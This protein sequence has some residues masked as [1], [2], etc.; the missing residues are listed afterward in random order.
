MQPGQKGGHCWQEDAH[1]APLL[2]GMTGRQQRMNEL[3][4]LAVGA[5]MCLGWLP[6][7]HDGWISE[8]PKWLANG[9]NRKVSCMT[10]DETVHEAPRVRDPHPRPL[11]IR[12]HQL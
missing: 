4:T 3:L 6:S 12:V 5:S 10:G 1:P 8:K 11:E 7:F 9:N 2:V